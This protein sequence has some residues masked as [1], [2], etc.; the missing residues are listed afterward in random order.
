MKLHIADEYSSLHDVAVCLGTS[1]PKFEDY[2]IDDPEHTKYNQRPW[3]PELFVR[4]QE[5]F[6]KRLQ[7]YG[8]RV[9]LIEA[10]PGLVHQAYT[11]DTAFVVRDTLYYTE[12]RTFKERD[13]EFELLKKLLDSLDVTNIHALPGNIDGGD[14]LVDPRGI[15]VGKGSR[16]DEV[17]IKELLENEHGRALELGNE[18]MHLDTRL[19]LLPRGYALVIPEAFSKDDIDMLQNRYKLLHVLPEE[20][21]ELGTNVFVVNPETIFSPTQNPRINDML[22]SEGFNVEE[23]DYSEPIA[24]CGSFR[25]T[26]LPLVRE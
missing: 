26:T 2:Q 24:L 13:G 25:C 9:H 6:I 14:V 15:F 7:K 17:A 16:T 23:V 20:A 11:R 12:T 1:V 8:V 3:D 18:V 5:E 10:K 19:T 4:Q 21:V 22:R